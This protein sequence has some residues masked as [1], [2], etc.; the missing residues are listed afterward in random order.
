MI[1]IGTLWVDVIT[2][3]GIGKIEDLTSAVIGFQNDRSALR[4]DPY[5]GETKVQARMF[6]VNG[7]GIIVEQQQ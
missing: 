7:L 3:K 4:F 5:A 6:P 1:I 2:G